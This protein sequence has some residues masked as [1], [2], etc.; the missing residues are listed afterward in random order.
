M[1]QFFILIASLLLAVVQIKI[2]IYFAIV[3]SH[4][5][6]HNFGISI[7]LTLTNYLAINLIKLLTS[8]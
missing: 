2:C 3:E 5:S 1:N 4:E 8:K 6:L 7:L